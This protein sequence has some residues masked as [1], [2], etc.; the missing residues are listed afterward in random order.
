MNITLNVQ[1]EG[2]LSGQSPCYNATQTITVAGNGNTFFVENGGSATMI[3]GQNIIYL[4]GTTVFPGGYLHGYITTTNQYCIPVP[5]VKQAITS[6]SPEPDPAANHPFLRVFP[7]PTSGVFT[8]DIKG[9]ESFSGTVSIEIFDMRGSKVVETEMSGNGQLEMS[10]A[11][12][13]AG[14]YV[15]HA[16]SGSRTETSKIIRQ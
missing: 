2:I 10:L 5:A 16:Y 6:D 12:K 14:I 8:L 9:D 7:N 13:P 3:A 1:N 15:I 11:G 4:P